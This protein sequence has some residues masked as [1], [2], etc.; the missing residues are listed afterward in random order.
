MKLCLSNLAWDTERNEEIYLFMSEHGFS[1]LEIAPTKLFGEN[2]YEA[3]SAARAWAKKLKKDYS[4]SVASVQSLWYKRNE[5]IFNSFEERCFLLS[6]TKKAIDF[7][8]EINCGN[9]V[10]GCP[11]NRVTRGEDHYAAALDFFGELGNYA[12]EKGAVIAIEPNPAA[13]GTDFLNTTREALE[14]CKD[15]GCDGLKINLDFGTIIINGESFDFSD[16]EL[17]LVNH[18]HISEPNLTPVKRRKGH[19]QL[20]TALEKSG[21]GGY[22]SVEMSPGGTD[23]DIEDAALYLKE[24]FG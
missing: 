23:S 8:A 17:A 10:F 5:G 22:V 6:Y 13:Y 12:V 7:A 21:Y 16:E 1:G 4:L 2:P 19:E 9:L 18:V 11:K 14:F 20:K 3:L 15:A 24:V